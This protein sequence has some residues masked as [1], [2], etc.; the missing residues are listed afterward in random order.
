MGLGRR[1]R[2]HP[3]SALGG[4][5]GTALALHG[6]TPVR[7][8]RPWPRWPRPAPGAAAALTEVL[9]AGRWSVAAPY[10]G[11]P[12]RDRRFAER[13]AAYL[14]V[15]HCVPTASGTAAGDDGPGGVRCRRGRRGVVPALSWSASASTVPGVNAVPVFA[16]VDPRTLCLDPAAAEAAITP[17]TRALVVVHLY[18][19]PA[20]LDA[21]RAVADRH[22]LP[23][24]EDSAQ[25][26]GAGYRG[27]A[28]GTTGD[29]GTF[30]M[31]HTKVLSSGEGGAAVTDDAYLAR[32]IEQLRAD[33]RCRAESPPEPGVPELVETGELMGSN[34]CLSEFQSALLPAQLAQL[35]AQ[36]A[37]R[38]ANAALLDGLL[39]ALGL[40]PQETSE[41]TTGRTYFGTPSPCPRRSSRASHRGPWPARSPPNSGQ[42]CG[43]STGR[44][45]T[46]RSTSRRPGAV[47]TRR[48][49]IW[50]GSTRAGTTF[51]SAT[52]PPGPSSPST[53]RRCWAARTTCATSPRRSGGSA[54]PVTGWSADRPGSPRR[55]P[56][57]P[58][59]P[60]TPPRRPPEAPPPSLRSPSL[61]SPSLRS[62]SLRSPSLRSPSVR[63]LQLPH[64]P[65]HPRGRP[66]RTACGGSGPLTGSPAGSRPPPEA[67]PARPARR[68]AGCRPCR[69]RR[70]A[71]G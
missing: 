8:G 45:T 54:T 69:P 65:R 71:A 66:P 25:A 27:R 49:V 3:R 42:P 47:S 60:R 13:F 34:R 11:G 36:N 67:G 2:N 37:T 19:A 53:T 33:G 56:G 59:P 16:D 20:D 9:H 17:A 63:P 24:I 68:R 61:R 21:L 70:R 38:R 57:P 1:R 41:G 14:G 15:R 31:H 10:T 55:P 40:R 4:S 51:P 22:G 7:A 43:R 23:L 52:G 58:G 50:S 32:R 46:A 29:V 48:P 64:P 30:S 6:G 62:P 44:C 26:H 12:A 28:A 39:A 5:T 35:D 18:S